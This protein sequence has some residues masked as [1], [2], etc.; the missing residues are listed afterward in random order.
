MAHILTIIP[1]GFR[2]GKRIQTLSCMEQNRKSIQQR[3][4]CAAKVRQ[5][6]ETDVF[7]RDKHLK[8]YSQISHGEKNKN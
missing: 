2:V 8:Q 5:Q 7:E 1:K 4:D 3:L 6:L